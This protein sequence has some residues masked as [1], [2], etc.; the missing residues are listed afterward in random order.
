MNERSSFVTGIL[1]PFERDRVVF[2]H[3]ATHVDDD[4]SVSEIDVMVCHCAASERLSQSRYS[5]AV[6][7]AGLMF[8]IN[9][10]K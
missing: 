2:R 8:N 1:N 5:G 4:I 9:E 10:A 6:S 3:I 7:Y